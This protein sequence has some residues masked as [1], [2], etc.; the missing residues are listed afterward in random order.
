MHSCIDLPIVPSTNLMRKNYR[1]NY[2]VKT[3]HSYT[4][5]YIYTTSSIKIEFKRKHSAS[6]VAKGALV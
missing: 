6:L 2:G 3:H 4:V 1:C 5:Y